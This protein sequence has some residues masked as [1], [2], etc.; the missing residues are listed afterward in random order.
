[1]QLPRGPICL[2]AERKI[3]SAYW[4]VKGNFSI[5]FTQ[6]VCKMITEKKKKLGWVYL[7]DVF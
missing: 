5:F 4:D 2:L 3:P 7:I 6:N 1:M